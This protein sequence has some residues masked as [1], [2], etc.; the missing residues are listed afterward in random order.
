MRALNESPT[1]EAKEQ[2]IIDEVS[3][4][5]RQILSHQQLIC[6]DHINQDRKKSRTK[7]SPPCIRFQNM[8]K[9]KM[10]DFQ[11]YIIQNKDLQN[12]IYLNNVK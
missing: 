11:N 7:L 5:I 6:L 3:T 1:A 4:M 9:R 10:S 2:E 12:Q 8:L